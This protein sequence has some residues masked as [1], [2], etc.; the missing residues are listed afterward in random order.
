M[1]QLEVEARAGDWSGR[2]FRFFRGRGVEPHR[3]EELAQEV[4]ARSLAARGSPNAPRRFAP[5]IY[6]VA[7]NLL[8][9]EWRSAWRRHEEATDALWM[10]ER[11]GEPGEPAGTD[12]EQIAL[13]REARAERQQAVR[14]ALAA[15]SPELRQVVLLRFYR[16]RSV[17]AIAAELGLPE[18]TVKSRLYR[19]YRLLECEL[20]PLWREER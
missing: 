10:A 11:G 7:A 17:K 16:G 15:L 6:Q 14:R 12:P 1:G 9:D 18:G 13:D 19:A 20:E 5:W 8:K 2:L 4:L 3:A